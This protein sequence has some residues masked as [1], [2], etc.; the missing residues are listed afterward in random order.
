VK[1]VS[2]I[3]TDTG[4]SVTFR[5]CQL[6]G[7]KTDV[8]ESLT[9]KANKDN[10]KTINDCKVCKEDACNKSTTLQITNLWLLVIPLILI[11]FFV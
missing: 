5:G 2:N 7:G 6:D 8:C 10:R 4:K 1:I 3:F 9:A 11:K